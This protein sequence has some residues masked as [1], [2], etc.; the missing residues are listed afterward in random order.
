M[1]KTGKTDSIHVRLNKIEK[2]IILKKAKNKNMS[3]SDFIRYKALYEP[4]QE[5]M[6]K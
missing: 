6:K 2:D 4:F 3:I 1:K 5:D